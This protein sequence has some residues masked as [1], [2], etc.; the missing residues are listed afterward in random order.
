MPT[1]TYQ[2]IPKRKTNLYFYQLLFGLILAIFA[3]LFFA[4]LMSSSSFDLWI[5]ILIGI[6]GTGFW[7]FRGL[8]NEWRKLTEKT[9]LS[10]QNRTVSPFSLRVPRVIGSYRGHD[11]VIDTVRSGGR[12]GNYYTQITIFAIHPS[13]MNIEITKRSAFLPFKNKFFNQEFDKVLVVKRD[14]DELPRRVLSN[15]SLRQGLLDIASQATG[16][17]I[18]F[19]ENYL[20]YK[21]NGVIIDSDYLHAVLD[22]LLDLASAIEQ[23]SITAS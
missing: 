8:H 22:L 23:E 18:Q 7:H 15:I 9:G 10:Y 2:R 11:I 13:P 3:Y 21:E 19:G 4:Q 17:K 14:S 16:L 20:I 6:L 1:E 5:F 12:Y